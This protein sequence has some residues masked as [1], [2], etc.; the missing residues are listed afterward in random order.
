MPHMPYIHMHAPTHTH[1]GCVEPWSLANLLCAL[2]LMR[3]RPDA[4][5]RASIITRVT[6]HTPR[7]TNAA[8]A[9]VLWAL[10][11]CV[12]ACR[13]LVLAHS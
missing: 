11:R 8:L 6:D 7:F 1:P 2:P 10:G 4:R 12:L 5:L 3:V 9:N 13:S